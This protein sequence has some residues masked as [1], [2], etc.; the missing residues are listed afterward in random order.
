MKAFVA[1]FVL[2]AVSAHPDFQSRITGGSDAKANS[3]KS[4]VA[5]QVEFESGSKTCGG[6]LGSPEDKIITSA[7][8]VMR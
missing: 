8:C 5:I 6:I 2:A 7:S 3:I 1:I 4:F